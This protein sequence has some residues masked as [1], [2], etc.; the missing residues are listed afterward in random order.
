MGTCIKQENPKAFYKCYHRNL[1]FYEIVVKR[2]HM[3]IIG[4]SSSCH[5]T[6]TEADEAEADS[7]VV[8]VSTSRGTDQVGIIIIIIDLGP[9]PLNAAPLLQVQPIHPL[10]C[11]SG[12]AG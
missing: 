7:R 12:D 6:S 4:L 8:V 9:F 11:S 1:L 5:R 10:T 2:I 3:V